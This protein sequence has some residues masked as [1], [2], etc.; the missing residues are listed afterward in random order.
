[1]DRRN[2]LKITGISLIGINS[3]SFGENN[4]RE[5]NWIKCLDKLPPYKKL[6]IIKD[7]ENRCMITKRA[8]NVSEISFLSEYIFDNN[9]LNSYVPY[10]SNFNY[11]LPF[12]KYKGSIPIIPIN[13]LYW[14]WMLIEDIVPVMNKTGFRYIPEKTQILL[15]EENAIRIR[16]LSKIKSTFTY[17]REYNYV[18]LSSVIDKD[19]LI[20]FRHDNT[21]LVE[22]IE[23]PKLIINKGIKK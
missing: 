8:E 14:S 19:K 11:D 6:F 9:I 12:C 18:R 20:N 23:L 22:W 2:F 16:R 1:M 7:Q 15:K 10:G 13:K 21:R 17:R 3:L 4:K 5:L